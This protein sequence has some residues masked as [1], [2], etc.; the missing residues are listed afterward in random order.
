MSSIIQRGD[1]W[2]YI[3]HHQGR[4]AWKSLRTKDKPTAKR[5]QR[6]YDTKLEQTKSGLAPK[7]IRLADAIKSF[8]IMKSPSLKPRS[9]ETYEEKSRPV[10]DLTEFLNQ[11]DS[12][13]IAEY[14]TVRQNKGYSNSTI[15]NELLILRGAIK[16]ALECGNIG[17][18]PVKRWPAL[19]E[20]PKKP[21]RIGFY[22]IQEIEA[23]KEYFKGKEFE[24]CFIFAL[25]TGCRRSELFGAMAD[26]VNF[27]E[28]YLKI[29]VVK[30][31]S[32][33]DSGVRMIA[34]HP[35]LKEHLQARGMKPGP[36]FPEAKKHCKSWPHAQI[37]KACKELKI[38]Y[39]RFHGIRHTTATY[40]LYAG[41]DLRSIM[42]IM[43]WR[44]LETAQ[45]Y[46]HHVKTMKAAQEINKLPY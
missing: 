5:L 27:A 2:Y 24:G 20:I 37:E 34:L 3:Y 14:V 1:V 26:D 11:L 19:K 18:S 15:N 45:R 38:E 28:N 8:L 44:N 6:L 31:T 10:M 33:G 46:L 36:L 12:E 39:K 21:D 41:V 32:D 22:A 42:A 30:T 40:L 29:R 16:Y 13:L 4:Q 17:E 9:R 7:Q 35:T 43:G 25:Y 23:M